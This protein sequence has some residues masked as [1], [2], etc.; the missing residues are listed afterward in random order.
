LLCNSDGSNQNF[1]TCTGFDATY[2]IFREK[3]NLVAYGRTDLKRA[4]H[5]IAFMITSHKCTED[6]EYFYRS[7]SHITSS[8]SIPLSICY[9]VQDAS[10]SE[11]QGLK[12]V[13]PEACVLMCYFHS[14][15]NEY[16]MRVNKFMDGLTERGLIEFRDYF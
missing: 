4:Y 13:F 14:N 3:F 1:V 2:K 9:V 16:C 6:Y 15:Y 5:P 12:N 7:L 11:Y 8:L 10:L